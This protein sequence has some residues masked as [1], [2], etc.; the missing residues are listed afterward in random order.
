MA[1][2]LKSAAFAGAVLAAFG[3][4]SAQALPNLRPNAAGMQNGVVIVRNNGTA[5]AGPFIVTF[6]CNVTGGEG[7]CAD[8]SPAAEARYS[9][10]AFPD[11]G[12]I[13]VPRLARGAV[14]RERIIGWRALDWTPGSYTFEVIADPENAIVESNEAD[15]AGTH[16]RSFP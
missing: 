6:E 1:N 11:R 4:T 5:P 7:G 14:F 2:M 10:P 13:R 9:D 12:V 8:P 3:A 15:N 16:T